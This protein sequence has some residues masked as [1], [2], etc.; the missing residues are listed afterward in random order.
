MKDDKDNFFSN[1]ISLGWFCGTASA[2]SKYGLRSIS[3]PFDWYFSDL[4][5]VI[6]QMNID[7]EDFLDRERL[8][9]LED[10]PTRFSDSKYGFL[11]FHEIKKNLDTDYTDIKNKYDRR[12]RRF[13]ELTQEPTLFLRAVR[14]PEEKGYIV[15]EYEEINRVIKKN[16]PD[17]IIIYLTTDKMGRLPDT[18]LSFSLNI[19]DYKFDAT[20]LRCMFDKSPELL[21]FCRDHLNPEYIADNKRFDGDSNSSRA[22]EM[23]SMIKEDREEVSDSIRNIFNLQGNKGIYLWGI[24]YHG[25]A[26]L[27]FLEKKDIIIDG[28]VDSNLCGREYRGYMI[29]SFDSIPNNSNVVI[30]IAD[31]K[32]VDSIKKMLDAKNAIVCDYQRL[33]EM[34][35][36]LSD[37]T[38][39]VDIEQVF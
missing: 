1:C 39:S 9:V 14:S 33:Y 17:S 20:S 34:I 19:D 23:F 32:S 30:T 12:I 36:G 25:K 3:G 24:G 29:G 28:L 4:K 8:E 27:E 2:M 38:K 37:K 11:F 10:N 5:A 18:V 26:M 35:D 13:Q 6:T 16:N 22:A 21:Q 15:K 31:K 7:F